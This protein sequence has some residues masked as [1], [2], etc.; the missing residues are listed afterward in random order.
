M[1]IMNLLVVSYKINVIG[2]VRSNLYSGWIWILQTWGFESYTT[3]SV[4]CTCHFFLKVK[5]TLNEIHLRLPPLCSP[6][7]KWQRVES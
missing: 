6:E 1:S 2:W 4:S 5:N 7:Q 3:Y